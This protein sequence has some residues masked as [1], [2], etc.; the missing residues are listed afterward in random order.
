MTIRTISSFTVLGLGSLLMGICASKPAA[1]DGRHDRGLLDIKL[2]KNV[3]LDLGF[4]SRYYDDCPP[5]YSEGWRD[6]DDR[7]SRDHGDHRR[8]RDDRRGHDRR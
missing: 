7:W 3:H 8:D 1:A 4:G 5:V 6:R 2:A